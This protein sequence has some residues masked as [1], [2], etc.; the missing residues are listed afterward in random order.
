MARSTHLARDARVRLSIVLVLASCSTAS[1][2]R[3]GPSPD[4][5]LPADAAGDDAAAPVKGCTGKTT[6]PRDATWTIGGRKVRVHVPASYDPTV[7]TP[8]VLDIHGFGDDGEDQARISKVI[9]RSDA[10]GFIAIHPDGH[11]SPR[12]GNAGVCCGS[13]ASSGT[14][15]TAWIASVLDEVESQLCVDPDRVFAMGLSNGAF[16]TYRLACELADRIAAIGAVAGVVGIS[17]CT[18]SRP[19]PVFHVHGTS[20]FVIPY[21]GGGFHGN[22]SF[23]TTIARFTARN[24]CTAAPV[25]TFEDGDATCVTRGGCTNGADVVLC[26]I[27][28]GGH[29]WPHDDLDATASIWQFF[30][31]HPRSP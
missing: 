18:P 31:A 29:A 7:A 22:E 21:G 19:V 11:H 12:G 3:E 17:Q 23:A 1:T 9:A 10:A 6:P 27:D 14:D 2:S 16:M 20:D 13:A 30:A 25:T 24:G 26:T 15:D 5:A 28:G 8:V 4:A